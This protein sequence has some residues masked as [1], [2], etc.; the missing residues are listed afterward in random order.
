M[1]YR[2][3]VGSL[4]PKLRAAARKRDA[5]SFITPPPPPPD[6]PGPRTEIRGNAAHRMI[7]TLAYVQYK[8]TKC[9]RKHLGVY[10]FMVKL[11]F[12]LVLLLLSRFAMVCIRLGLDLAY[13]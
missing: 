7:K 12:R 11:R 9:P 3:L 8:K 6:N 10:Q 2:V 5:G 1:K 4:P 13:K